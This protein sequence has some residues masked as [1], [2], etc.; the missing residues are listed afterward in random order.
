MYTFQLCICISLCITFWKSIFIVLVHIGPH[1]ALSN[2]FFQHLTTLFRRWLRQS[3]SSL[4]SLF[5]SLATAWSSQLLDPHSLSGG[6]TT[7]CYSYR[8]RPLSHFGFQ[9]LQWFLIQV[10]VCG[11]VET[12]LNISLS[13]AYLLTQVD[14]PLMTN[15]H[16]RV[17]RY[18]D[19]Y[20]RYSLQN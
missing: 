6:F 12:G 13:T 18:F 17:K 14:V 7:T 20:S 16:L 5:P 15:F 9:T 2:N 4:S 10:G 8:S 19:S 1:P 3:F 11:I